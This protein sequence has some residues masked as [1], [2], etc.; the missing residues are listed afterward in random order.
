[1]SELVDNAIAGMDA[2]SYEEYQEFMILV[3]HSLKL[4]GCVDCRDD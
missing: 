3:M 2:M 4:D 1:M